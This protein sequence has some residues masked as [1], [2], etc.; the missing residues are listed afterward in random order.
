MDNNIALILYILAYTLLLAYLIKGKKS[1]VSKLVTGIWLFSAVCGYVY[2]NIYARF[3]RTDIDVSGEAL[4][5]LFVCFVISIYP[6]FNIQCS[7]KGLE[8]NY[9]K[10][11]ILAIFIIALN[12]LPFLANTLYFLT[13][14]SVAEMGEKYGGDKTTITGLPVMLNRYAIYLR[15]FTTVIFFYLLSCKRKTSIFIYAGLIMAIVN[16]VLNN[17]NVGSRYAFVL[18]TLFTLAIYLIFAPR[19]NSETKRLVK[20]VGIVVIGLFGFYFAMITINRFT[21]S[22]DF[23][24]ED[25]ILISTSL[26]AGESSVNFSTMMWGSENY[27]DGDN[28]FFIFKHLAGSYPGEHRDSE[29]LQIKSKLPLNT[30][31]TFIGD[32][33]I[34]FGPYGA[35]AFISLL[36]LTAMY[37]VKQLRKRFSFCS[38]IWIA[39]IIKII[40]AGFTYYPYMNVPFEIVYS[41][42]VNILLSLYLTTTNKKQLS[43]K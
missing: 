25:P 8:N 41:I 6:F 5:Y 37:L 24:D 26:Y 7:D 1:G 36:S 23:Q 34:D 12:L 9:S 35:F 11:K 39:I 43:I 3:F 16:P 2:Y 15:V 31:F 27:T 29:M 42:A 4:I 20:K 40:I 21:D 14:S 10:L 17:L 28:C 18:E 32:F 33:Y 22:F 19:I 38:L 30:F 13:H